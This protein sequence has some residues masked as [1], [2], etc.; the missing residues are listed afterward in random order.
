LAGAMMQNL[1]WSVFAP[2]TM[3]LATAPVSA[4]VAA[5]PADG[6]WGRAVLLLLGIA[7]LTIALVATLLLI[8]LI[9]R[10]RRLAAMQAA[11]RKRKRYADAWQVA[12]ERVP[13]PSA[14][15][16][17]R[18]RL[19]LEDTRL[20]DLNDGDLPNPERGPDPDAKPPRG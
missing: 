18:T 3:M 20:P 6:R 16:L 9:R 7:L 11:D 15:E 5:P 2:F 13:T 8:A 4:P 17:D 12:G 19:D 10:R 14:D 1:V